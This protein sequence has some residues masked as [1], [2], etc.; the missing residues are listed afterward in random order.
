MKTNIFEDRRDVQLHEVLNIKK[1]VRIEIMPRV[2]T[3]ESIS[4]DEEFTLTQGDTFEYV[5]E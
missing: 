5:I 4:E 3:S 2:S 1:L